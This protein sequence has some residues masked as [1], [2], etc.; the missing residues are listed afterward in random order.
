MENGIKGEWQFNPGILASPVLWGE[1]DL[2]RSTDISPDEALIWAKKR[3]DE[4]DVFL[5]N[6]APD[7][8]E[9]VSV[10]WP[11]GFSTLE[12]GKSK[13]TVR[14]QLSWS[15]LNPGD[16]EIIIHNRYAEGASVNWFTL[17]VGNHSGFE[18]PDQTRGQLAFVWVIPPA[19]NYP[20]MD[21]LLITW[22]SGTPR[23]PSTTNQPEI[24]VE[25]ITRPPPT[26]AE[27]N[28]LAEETSPA[29]GTDV[30]KTP[31]PGFKSSLPSEINRPAEMLSG[32]LVGPSLTPGQIVLMFAAALLLGGIHA[33]TP[34]H[35]KALVAAYLVGSRGTLRHAAALGG[36]VTLTHTGS[37]VLI[38]SLILLAANLL[39]PQIVIPGLEILSGIIIFFLGLH[40]FY[41]GWRSFKSLH[42]ARQN[43]P[44]DG[45]D[46]SQKISINQP[47]NVRVFDGVLSEGGK[48]ADKK[49]WRSLIALGISGGLVPCPDAIAILFAAVAI[50]R[51]VLGLSV[52]LT[53]SLGMAVVLILIGSAVVRSRSLLD[54]S[55]LLQ[56]VSHLVPM[57]SGLIILGLGLGL[58]IRSF[59]SNPIQQSF[60]PAVTTPET[61]QEIEKPQNS[62]APLGSTLQPEQSEIIPGDILYIGPDQN[63]YYQ[64][65]IFEIES[66][67][68]QQL[69]F[70]SRGI[71]DY[72]LAPDGERVAYAIIQ[73]NNQGEI[74]EINLTNGVDRRLTLFPNA[75]CKGLTW[76]PDG[77]KLLFEVIDQTE[78]SGLGINSLWWID[79]ETLDKKPV[80]QEAQ[81]P[82]FGASWSPNGD[83]L[84]FLSPG[85][86]TTMMLYNIRTQE[87]LTVPVQSGI[88][89][90]WSPDSSSLIATNLVS[91]NGEVF[92]QLVLFDLET[93]QLRDL[94]GGQNTIDAYAAFSPNGSWIAVVR[95]LQGADTNLTGDQI[96]LISPDGSESKQLSSL[97]NSVY[98]LPVF[99]PDGRKILY[100]RIPLAD[101]LSESTIETIDI[102]SGEITTITAP[103]VRPAWI[104]K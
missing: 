77:T 104:P 12:M 26:S 75:V 19:D 15:E 28:I 94:S 36:I 31:T 87:Q 7:Q 54:K 6:Q 65:Q 45:N 56:R 39:L 60:T 103:G 43:S 25:V 17:E 74:R 38:G 48:I 92:S 42:R 51:I 21:D 99:S 49:S 24:T 23:I 59:R 71:L 81:L 70:S 97:N 96:W 78:G 2:D 1:A 63:N 14:Y 47:I 30:P 64:L 53:F 4:L 68:S 66:G 91:Q 62:P 95:S 98:G 72:A 37:V 10:D 89:A 18:I 11:E 93:E 57:L 8:V 9:I 67:I 101:S 34:G 55:S 102:K 84:S 32:L 83:W 16:H 86:T 69:T 41:R 52:I 100:Q 5:D 90:V 85:T 79:P 13:V 33:L 88:P 46:K 61:E 27:G 73:Q 50:N 58:S 82:S 44:E 76:S 35:G 20:E 40:L 80:F 3:L 22:N 29:G